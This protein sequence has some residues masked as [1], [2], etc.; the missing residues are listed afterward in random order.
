MTRVG[1]RHWD[2]RSPL[3]IP[4]APHPACLISPQEKRQPMPA[5][6]SVAACGH[7]N[8]AVTRHVT[9]VRTQLHLSKRRRDVGERTPSA[10]NPPNLGLNVSK[11]TGS[12]L[13]LLDG[14]RT[15]EGTTERS[16]RRKRGPNHDHALA[17][18]LVRP[19]ATLLT[20]L[21]SKTSR[22]RVNE[23]G[24]KTPRPSTKFRKSCHTTM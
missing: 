8:L 19:R 4:G 6:G 5:Q 23:L 1:A 3:G 22:H 24:T 15:R 2:S 10:K 11:R 13:A 9:Q 20:F 14:A 12:P 21:H 7:A 18:G 16:Q 17:R